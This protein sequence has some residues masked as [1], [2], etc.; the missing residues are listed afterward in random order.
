MEFIGSDDVAAP[1]LK[2]VKL[3]GEKIFQ[4]V[5]GNFKKLYL[6]GIVHGDLSEYNILLKG[7]E[8]YFIDLSQ[9]VPLDHPLAGELLKRDARNIARYFGK[10]FDKVYGYIDK[11]GEEE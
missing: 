7:R 5:M 3:T 4:K 10:N 2:E 9:S 1:T 8:P 11:N 6:A